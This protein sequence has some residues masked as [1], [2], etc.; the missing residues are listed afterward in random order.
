MAPPPP[1]GCGAANFCREYAVTLGPTN[2]SGFRGLV[3]MTAKADDMTLNSSTVA[4][5][6]PL[7]VTRWKW[8]RLVSNGGG[9][10]EL[11]SSP[12][13][14]DGGMLYLGIDRPAGFGGLA[15]VTD[16]GAIQQVSTVGPVIASPAV[17]FDGTRNWVFFESTNGGIQTIENNTCGTGEGANQGGLA[18]THDGLVSMRAL[19]LAPSVGLRQ[20][21]ADRG[22]S[23]CGGEFSAELGS[24]ASMTFPGNLVTDDVSIF[25]PSTAGVLKRFS[26]GVPIT[27][28]PDTTVGAGAISGIALFTSDGGLKV[29]GGGGGVGIGRVFVA[30]ADGGVTGVNPMMT[31]SGVAVGSDTGVPALFAVLQDGSELASLAKFD[32]TGMTS[33]ASVPLNLSFPIATTPGATTPVLGQGGFVYVVSSNGTVVIARQSNLG[34][35]WQQSLPVGI[36][37]SVLASPTLDCNRARPGTNTGILYFATGS[38]WL[39]SYIVDSPGLDTTAPWPKYQHDAR[40]TGNSTVPITACP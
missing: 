15:A 38:G 25:Y 8:A 9:T 40:N 3:T 31:V 28:S 32:A 11:K 16:Q 26:F 21:L 34:L 36:T 13:V 14:D 10:S 6:P 18:I 20:V 17:G 23:G 2:F 37:G 30:S 27:T 12:A 33:L 5:S 7:G 19:G 29:A 39:V 24:V 22:G 1:T 35:R 4:S